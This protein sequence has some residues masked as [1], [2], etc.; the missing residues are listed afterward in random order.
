MPPGGRPSRVSHA[1]AQPVGGVSSSTP[2]I[3]NTTARMAIV[4]LLYSFAAAQPRR[5]PIVVV[6]G[7]LVKSA[8]A[9]SGVS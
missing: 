2:P 4:T 7:R 6:T 8:W 1:S 3:S 9:R 5:G